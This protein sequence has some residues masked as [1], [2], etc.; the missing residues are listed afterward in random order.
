[1]YQLLDFGVGEVLVADA[2][3]D[4]VAVEDESVFEADVLG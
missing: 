4:F 3:C 1:M 2:L